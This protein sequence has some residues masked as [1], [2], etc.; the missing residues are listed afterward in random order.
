MKKLTIIITALVLTLG[1][2]QCK[3]SE[4]SAKK[5][6]FV[7][8]EANIGNDAKTD[9]T[10]PDGLVNWSAGDKLYVVGANQGYLG[11]LTTSEG[12]SANAFFEGELL[13]ITEGQEVH[14]YYFGKNG[15]TISES[16]TTYDYS[17]AT[18]DGT[19]DDIEN[20]MHLMHGKTTATEGQLHFTVSMDNMM[21][22]AY[23][24]V[25]GFPTCNA[26]RSRTLDLKNGTWSGNGESGIITL[27]SPSNKYYMAL[28]PSETKQTLNFASG[29][30]LSR[31][32]DAGKYYTDNGNPIKP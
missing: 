4:T 8:L 1:M 20:A 14:F 7:T 32:I 29:H 21:A 30:E 13:A 22:I 9:I 6:V 28:I 27:N 16:T 24:D 5:S 11:E 3:K 10:L 23:F 12:G 19:L 26:I 31:K 18:Q 2:A 17:I 25:T 15:A